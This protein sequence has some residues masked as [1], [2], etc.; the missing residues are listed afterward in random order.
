MFGR[1]IYEDK[2]TLKEADEYQSNLLNEIRNFDNKTRKKKLFL[3]TC[4]NFLTQE[5]C[6][7][8]VLIVKYF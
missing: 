6:F 7:L 2:I 8:M 5:K 4:I 1:N 3:K